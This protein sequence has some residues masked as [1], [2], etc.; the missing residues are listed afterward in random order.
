MLVCLSAACL[1]HLTFYPPY[2]SCGLSCCF[3]E[4]NLRP[5]LRLPAYSFPG[6]N[7]ETKDR[8]TQTWVYGQLSSLV[9]AWSGIPSFI[10]LAN[11][12]ADQLPLVPAFSME[13]PRY[14]QSEIYNRGLGPQA[15]PMEFYNI[16]T[17]NY[18]PMWL[19]SAGQRIVHSSR[20][21]ESICR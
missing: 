16:P 11:G 6:G 20:P 21:H 15:L 14:P 2:L 19:A 17:D 5:P 3:P 8:L 1:W 13:L 7:L 10:K 18:I 9:A 12:F 4:N